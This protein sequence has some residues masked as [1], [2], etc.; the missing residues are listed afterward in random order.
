MKWPAHIAERAAIFELTGQDFE[1][2]Q[3]PTRIPLVWEDDQFIELDPSRFP[4][5]LRVI[6]V[7]R[8]SVDPQ[9]PTESQS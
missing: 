8:V 1:P 3:G 2:L 9:Q 7:G 4:K 5:E 6:G